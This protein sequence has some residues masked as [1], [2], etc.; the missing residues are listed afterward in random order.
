LVIYFDFSERY[1]VGAPVKAI[2]A[3][4]GLPATIDSKFPKHFAQHFS[5][6][7]TQIYLP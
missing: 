1:Y 6:S 2:K 7:I 5:R 4:F 3:Y